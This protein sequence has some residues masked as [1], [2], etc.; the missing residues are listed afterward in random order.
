M[1][2]DDDDDVETIFSANEKKTRKSNV[3]T[4]T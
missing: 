4:G 2:D 1:Y 3:K